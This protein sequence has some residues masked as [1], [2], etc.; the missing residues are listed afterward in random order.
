MNERIFKYRAVFS[1]KGEAVYIS[2]LDV[3]T[4]FRRAIRRMGLP[5]V[6]TKGFTPRVK[7]SIPRALKLGA[8]SSAEEAFLFFRSGQEE[9]ALMEGLT[10]QFPDGMEVTE[11]EPV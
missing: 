8:E 4:L 7:I 11:I 2:H 3:M 6:L 9:K 10:A 1:K 5:F